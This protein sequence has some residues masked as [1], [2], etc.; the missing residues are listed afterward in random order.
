MSDIISFL[1]VVYSVIM[2]CSLHHMINQNQ[3]NLIILKIAQATVFGPQFNWGFSHSVIIY[4][5]MFFF[6][7]AEV[8]KHLFVCNSR[9]ISMYQLFFYKL[10]FSDNVWVAFY[11]KI[12][13][14]FL[15]F[16]CVLTCTSLPHFWAYFFGLVGILFIFVHKIINC[17]PIWMIV[18]FL[19]YIVFNVDFN[20]QIPFWMG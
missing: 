11:Y 19:N 10:R 2:V 4:R 3:N 5:A 14:L 13:L 17:Y 6:C 7:R 1:N 15:L 16:G 9:Y 20:G 18:F 8:W 12:F